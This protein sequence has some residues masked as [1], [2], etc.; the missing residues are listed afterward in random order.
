MKRIFFRVVVY[1]I[2]L[3]V[4]AF[5]VVFTINSDLGVS[6]VNSLPYAVSLVFDLNLG[7]CVTIF[8]IIC[9][10]LQIVL[11]RR[12]FKWIN[13]A[14]IIFSTIFGVFVD[15]ARFVV[16]DFSLPT[17]FGQLALLVMGILCIALGLVIYLE[18]KLVPLPPE[19][20]VLAI[21]SKL[22]NAQF[23]IIKVMLDSSLVIAAVILLFALADEFHGV[24]EGTIISA[25]AIG[26][27]MPYVKRPVTP[28]L[29]KVGFYRL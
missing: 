22:K 6:P 21:V 8:F 1:V 20:L 19:G 16:G 4:L 14:Q 9:I 2:G 11:L 12:E 13:L 29:D 27:I 15:L 24:R 18:T 26:K 28:I 7:M 5:G 17:Y 10:L 23:H 3:L 25:L